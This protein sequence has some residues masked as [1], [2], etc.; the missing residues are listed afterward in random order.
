[1]L[2]N[3][4]NQSTENKYIL[5]STVTKSTIQNPLYVITA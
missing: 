2:G 4:C 3:A 5:M 1:M